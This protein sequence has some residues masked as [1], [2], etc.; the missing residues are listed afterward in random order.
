[1]QFSAKEDI[2]APIA[3]VFAQVTDFAAF[4]RQAMRRG[5][6]VRRRDSMVRPGVGSAWDIAFKYRGKDR[7]IR[8]EISAFDPPHGYSVAST[9]PGLTGGLAVEL[10]SLSR[11]R[12]RLS[13]TLDVEAR[14]IGT[15]ILLQSLRLAKG[16]VTRRLENRLASFA[17]QVQD[18]FGASA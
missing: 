14:S 3:F 11:A 5:A 17:V 9:S 1:M 4:E 10:V 16:N 2:E 8:A 18:R 6:E 7:Q 13:I 15:R 12:T